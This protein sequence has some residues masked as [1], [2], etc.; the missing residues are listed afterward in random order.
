MQRIFDFYIQPSSNPVLN[1]ARVETN[2]R[3]QSKIKIFNRF[4]IRRI[5]TLR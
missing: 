4:E 1:P 2:L 3:L 5:I